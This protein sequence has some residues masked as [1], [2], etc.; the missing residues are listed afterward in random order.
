M[1]STPPAAERNPRPIDWRTW[2]ALAWAL[3]FGVL[4]GR[5]VITERAP[6]VLHVIGRVFEPIRTSYK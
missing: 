6:G 5:M 4:Y 2:L 3:W 1:P